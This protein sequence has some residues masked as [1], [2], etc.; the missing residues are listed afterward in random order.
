MAD[1]RQHGIDVSN[2]R[3]APAGSM[4]ELLL[5]AFPLVVS[6]GSFSLMNVVDRVFLARLSVEA[7]AA[8]MPSSML[9]W[10]VM[11]LALGVAGYTNAFASQYEGAGRK[12]RVTSA[13][14]Q[15]FWIALV[16]GIS[17]LPLMLFARQI[18]SSMGHAPEVV[19]LEITY[20]IWLCPVAIP[21]LLSTVFSA[22]FAARKKTSVIM[23]VNVSTAILNAVADYILI[24]GL[25]PIPGFGMRGAAVATILAQSTGSIVLGYLMFRQGHRDGYPF[26]ATFGVDWKLL[27]RMVRYGIPNGIHMFMDIGAFTFFVALVGQL[28]TNEQAAT[29]LAF[30]LNSLAFVP[31]FGMGTAIVTLV[32]HRVGEGR[33]ELAVKTVWKAFYLSGS[34]MIIFAAIY[35]SL[36][37]L[38]LSPFTH[39]SEAAAFKEIRPIVIVLLQYI[40][41]YTFFDAMAIVFGSAIRGA[42]DI[43]F[44]LFFSIACSW[45]LMVVPSV[46]AVRYGW[47]LHGCWISITVAVLVMGI[48]FLTRFQLGYWKSMRVIESPH[49]TLPD[50]ETTNG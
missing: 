27:K 35:L 41:L 32:G 29:N 46:L 2:T 9:V 17:L 5:V 43:W 11:S 48:G 3:G 14:W 22:Y 15:G 28:G 6:A 1:E 38:I 26:A 25:G 10:T 13:I 36:P 23:W 4:R 8:S 21:T 37:D 45:L 24:F 33:P 30:T 20:F 49:D 19:E 39:E 40:A 34:Y 31:M 44:S 16:G 18:F 7:L 12:E 50:S 42:G 47:G